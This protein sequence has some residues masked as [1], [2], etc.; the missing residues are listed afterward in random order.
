MENSIITKTV[1]VAAGTLGI[2]HFITQS[3]AD[4]IM[5]AEATLV[6]K[7]IGTDKEETRTNRLT[8]TLTRQQA[9]LDRISKSRQFVAQAEARMQSSQE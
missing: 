7:A 8:I 4:L 9:V 3:T 6:N 1:Q 2:L 5:E